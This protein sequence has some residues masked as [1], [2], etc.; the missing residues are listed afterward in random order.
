MYVCVCACGL[1]PIV[2][3]LSFLE[4]LSTVVFSGTLFV[5]SF[6]TTV[7]TANVD[8]VI[9]LQFGWPCFGRT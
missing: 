7:E 9:V 8:A 6:P 3:I 2:S 1:S 5:T 4:L